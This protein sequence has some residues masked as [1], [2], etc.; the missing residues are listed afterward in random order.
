M[1]GWGH[2]YKDGRTLSRS[3]ISIVTMM[4]YRPFTLDAYE[5]PTLAELAPIIEGKPDVTRIPE[6]SLRDLGERFRV[7]KITS[8]LRA[9]STSR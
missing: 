3:G 8:R 6:S 5:T 1:H 9:T 4:L 2:L 7:Q